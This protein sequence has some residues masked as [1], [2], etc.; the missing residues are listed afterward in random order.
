[1]FSLTAHH[2]L[3]LRAARSQLYGFSHDDCAT[4]VSCI[5]K[6]DFYQFFCFR[7]KIIKNLKNSIWQP[8]NSNFIF[9]GVENDVE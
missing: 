5:N 4:K 8:Q 1:M 7:V 9:N 2:K 6:P 3:L